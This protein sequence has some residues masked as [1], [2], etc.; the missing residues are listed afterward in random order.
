MSAQLWALAVV[1]AIV[2]AAAGL[3]IFRARLAR[4]LVMESTGP[5][6]RSG[7][8]PMNGEEPYIL[9]F[10][11][12]SCTVCRTHQEPA[13]ARLGDVRI[14]KVDAVNERVLADQF[15]VYTLPTTVVMGADGN[16]L[17]INYGYAPAPKLERQLADARGAGLRSAA[18]A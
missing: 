6:G 2:L 16:A 17:H 9:Y 18:T 11:G 8:L 7:H 10:T 5:S 13:L 1:G 4:R 15:H 3:E 12:D 14:D